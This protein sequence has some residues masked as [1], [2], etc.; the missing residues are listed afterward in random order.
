MASDTK[1]GEADAKAPLANGSDSGGHHDA[2]VGRVIDGCKII[3]KI[4][5]G[6]M[7]VVYLAVHES[8]NQEFVL[9]ILNPALTGAEDTVDRFFREAQACAQ[10]N[11][12]AIVAI[13]NVGQDNGVYYIRMEFIEG[14]TLEDLLKDDSQLDWREATRL[15]VMV[16]DALAHAHQKGMIHRDIKPENI[17]KM[18]D[19]AVKVMDFGLAKHVHSS[20]KV[21]VTGQIVGTPFFM[22]PEQAGGKPTDAR[23]DIYSLGVT[24][25]YMVTG[26]KPFNGKNLQEIFLKHF[27]YAP[28]SPKIYNDALPESLCEVVKTCLKKKKK[29]R[30]QSAK[31][32][33]RDLQ[34]ILDN[35]DSDLGE[36]RAKS[37]GAAASS[38]GDA[39]EGDKTMVAGGGEATVQVQG[40]GATIRVDADSDGSTI[41]VDA[42]GEATVQVQGDSEA[43][44][45]VQ[46]DSDATVQVQGDGGATVR[47]DDEEDAH[48][49]LDL[50]TAMI[51]GFGLDANTPE[52][53]EAEAATPRDLKKIGIAIGVVV[54][55]PAILLGLL[56]FNA[57]STF[58]EL[59]TN[60][61]TLVKA[62]DKR[63]DKLL[64]L[65]AELEKFA[66]ETPFAGSLAESARG[67]KSSL[68]AEA[69]RIKQDEKTRREEEER[70]AAAKREADRIA[71]E[72]VKVL[73]DY[74]RD[75]AEVLRV[76]DEARDKQKSGSVEAADLWQAYVEGAK[77][78]LTEYVQKRVDH[79]EIDERL[80]RIRFPVFVTSDP[81]GADVLVKGVSQGRT[82]LV[83]RE[84]PGQTVTVTIRRKG[85]TDATR[86][87]AVKGA[88]Y[89][90]CALDRETLR[91]PLELGQL[92]VRFGAGKIAEEVL[93]RTSFEAY[94]GERLVFVGH[95][96]Y[97]RSYS[98]QSGRMIWAEDQ[99][100]A[101]AR[102]GDPVAD[103]TVIEGRAILVASPLGQLRAHSPGNGSLIWK[104]QLDA[105]ATSTPVY[106]RV[107]KLL[108]VGTASGSVYLVDDAG[109]IKSTF[110]TENPVVSPPYFYG[111][112]IC[113]IGSTDNRLYAVDWRSGRVPK[114]LSRLDLGSDVVVGPQPV[115][116]KLVVGTGNGQVH[117]I[118]VSQRGKLSLEV[119]LGEAGEDPV[120]GI[121]VDGDALYFAAGNKLSSYDASGKTRWPEP[122][123]ASGTLTAP[124]T[125][126]E[127]GMLYVGDSN[128]TLYAV[129]KAEGESRWR[130]PI[131]GEGNSIERP[132]VK[133][134]EEL[135]VC[136][137]GKIYV[138]AAD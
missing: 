50:P 72:R 121:V 15:C 12:P 137:G 53:E 56:R 8:L 40:E 68:E 97:L 99:A 128:G 7:G 94:S 79:K 112:K 49:G 93:P 82:P 98:P 61:A 86:S 75:E 100:H 44:I 23:S 114:E 4:G 41:R 134:G 42:E 138:L 74:K 32:L 127:G 70:K 80:N 2:L 30:Y 76:E 5:Q 20:A 111:D 136:S 135:L 73:A 35:P 58:E 21:S 78:L 65:A 87:G 45:Q 25:Y 81:S 57:T 46:S 34:A 16:A 71:K 31:A 89:L 104:V 96:G 60:Y 22:S 107:F 48:A 115:G 118:G 85:F 125:T 133:V 11:H 63:P 38:S 18:P 59:K 103:L 106:K 132:P 51:Q 54:L 64:S 66:V 108:A 13:Q 130:F 37:E 113:V 120:R 126:L 29:E 62:K 19:G 77:K 117:V 119:S 55:I 91:E 95:G 1:I 14:E 110:Q 9:K 69:A 123:A 116:R 88:L 105:P 26:V 47:V 6:G 3:K 17:M 39:A 10:L 109:E 28:E 33:A 67:L 24:L 92:A 52:A 36:A 101:V 131:P 27:F 43:T 124:Y 129:G 122:F 102:Y 83:L 90:D 84:K